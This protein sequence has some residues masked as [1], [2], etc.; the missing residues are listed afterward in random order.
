MMV[1]KA[2]KFSITYDNE[3]AAGFARSVLTAKVNAMMAAVVGSLWQ[4]ACMSWHIHW[5]HTLSRLGDPP[6][7]LVAAIV[8]HASHNPDVRHEAGH[9][10]STWAHE[11]S[12]E[13]VKLLYLVCLPDHLQEAYPLI[14]SDGRSICATPMATEKL[15]LP[16]SAV[17]SPLDELQY[18]K[19]HDRQWTAEPVTLATYNVHSARSQ[20]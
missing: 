4:I 5:I 9:P 20:W 7:E 10:C 6:N 14:R 1:D 19:G 17:A 13:Q 8:A 18:R 3:S 2:T 12:V 16:A 15:G 11:Y